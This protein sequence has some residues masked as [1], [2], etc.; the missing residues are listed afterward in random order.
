MYSIK[1]VNYLE[2]KG[3]K[4]KSIECYLYAI[5]ILEKMYKKY[6]N[7]SYLAIRLIF[8]HWLV[9]ERILFTYSNYDI[10]QEKIKKWHNKRLVE[11]YNETINKF[12]DR[13]FYLWLVFF[14]QSIMP[15]TEDGEITSLYLF[16]NAIKLSPYPNLIL[17][18]SEENINF[19]DK[20]K[21]E[22]DARVRKIF[23]DESQF[24]SYF[25]YMLSIRKNTLL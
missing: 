24:S 9:P 1:D 12:N 25:R 18:S 19:S 2:N 20:E 4:N 21:D 13:W 23:S 6:P 22:I 5:G 11:I 14:M 8:S 7:N 10:K 17:S 15:F 3:N 16:E